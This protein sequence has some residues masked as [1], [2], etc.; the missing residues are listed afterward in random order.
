MYIIIFYIKQKKKN[1]Y[2]DQKKKH[3]AEIIHKKSQDL[4]L[5]LQQNVPNARF[6][7]LFLVLL[8]LFFFL[9]V[10]VSSYVAS[11]PSPVIQSC[12]CSAKRQCDGASSTSRTRRLLP[13]SGE[14]HVIPGP[15][16]C[17]RSF[18]HPLVLC[19]R[20]LLCPHSTR[21]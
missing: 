9:G 15:R 6:S 12:R 18:L 8:H 7:Q 11:L 20:V 19:T 4:K 1:R 14:P 16:W 21:Q 2:A 5:S 17:Q 10:T 13:A 3:W